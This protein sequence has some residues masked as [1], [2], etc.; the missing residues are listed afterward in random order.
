MI[1]GFGGGLFNYNHLFGQKAT[2]GYL[3]PLPVGLIG[4]NS[5][6]TTTNFQILE[7]IDIFDSF[8]NDF[9]DLAIDVAGFEKQNANLYKFITNFELSG[10]PF[11]A[12]KKM[13]KSATTQ[14]IFKPNNGTHV[15]LYSP[16]KYESGSSISHVR[17]EL[18]T[19]SNFLMVPN[20][21]PGISLQ[22]KGPNIYGNG[23]LQILESI[24]WNLDPT[25]EQKSI[26]L[27]L[28]FGGQV[29][30]RGSAYKASKSLFLLLLLLSLT[31]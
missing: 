23:I 4:K 2:T 11:E 12:A 29:G 26:E 25:K 7:P 18:S 24:G 17:Q 15:L 28:D 5:V 30:V 16:V 6:L 10:K 20:I 1:T 13:Y 9:K 31:I 3:A 21:G 19:S 22:S 27:A 14:L 8:I